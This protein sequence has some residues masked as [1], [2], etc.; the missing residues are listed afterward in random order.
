MF[1]HAGGALFYQFIDFHILKKHCNVRT[2]VFT[3]AEWKHLLL[4][5]LTLQIEH[6][7]AP[8][9]QQHR[10]FCLVLPTQLM[11]DSRGRPQLRHTFRPMTLKGCSGTKQKH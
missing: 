5:T 3:T 10:G 4:L 1:C 11:Q 8:Q 9:Q 7:S 6:S 2:P